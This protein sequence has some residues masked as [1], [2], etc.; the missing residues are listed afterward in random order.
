MSLSQR[1]SPH[2]AGARMASHQGSP[3]VTEATVGH[4]ATKLGELAIAML[5]PG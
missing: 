4:G 2:D 3:R 5:R 1:L